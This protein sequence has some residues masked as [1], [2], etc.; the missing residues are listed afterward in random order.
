[1]SIIE[2]LCYEG[3]SFTFKV[4][5]PSLNPHLKVIH[6]NHTSNNNNNNNNNVYFLLSKVLLSMG[7]ER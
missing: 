6:P 1:M 4:E 2:K 3:K 7:K 5:G